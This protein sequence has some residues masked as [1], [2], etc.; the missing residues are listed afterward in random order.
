[1]QCTGPYI[2]HSSLSKGYVI[3]ITKTPIDKQ[4]DIRE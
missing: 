1:M 2:S 3:L 4:L